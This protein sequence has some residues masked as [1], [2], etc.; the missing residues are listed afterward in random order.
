MPAVTIDLSHLDWIAL[1]AVA[2]VLLAGATVWL[3]SQTRDVS[4]RTGELVTTT[5]E[6]IDLLRQQ[7][8]AMKLQAESAQAQLN[9]MD[10]QRREDRRPVLVWRRLDSSLKRS[11]IAADDRLKYVNVQVQAI[12]EGGHAFVSDL[13]IHS[14]L[15]ELHDPATVHRVITVDGYVPIDLRFGPLR[16]DVDFTW[17]G[18]CSIKVRPLFGSEDETITVRTDFRGRSW[19]DNLTFDLLD[20]PQ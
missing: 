1:G 8:T 10:R 15:A 9:A 14:S 19:P 4:R 20:S 7:T 3:G 12:N 16:T 6:E 18:T 13:G 2:T 5:S 17:T 11:P